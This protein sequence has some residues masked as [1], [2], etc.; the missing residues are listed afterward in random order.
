M[1]VGSTGIYDALKKL[2]VDDRDGHIIVDS[3]IVTATDLDIRNLTSTDV[4]TDEVSKWGG[5]ALTGRDI[6][7]DLKTL[8]DAFITAAS[9]IRTLPMAKG[10]TTIVKNAGVV[11]G[12]A[13]VHTVTNGKTFYLTGGW[14]QVK[15]Y[16][17]SVN[18]SGHLDV[19]TGGNGVFRVLGTV[20]VW[21]PASTVA[22][23]VGTCQVTTC[24][25][26]P[27]PSNTVFN[28]ISGA[29]NVAANGGIM[30]WEE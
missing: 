10:I 4:V 27:F 14:I 16:A 15:A 26:M 18:D 22:G 1:S 3:A 20:T 9:A 2:F 19:D 25:A 17:S 29:A 30:G 24:A 13:T 8:T 23:C 7:L 11:N 12:T 28:I 21:T 6:S 5:T